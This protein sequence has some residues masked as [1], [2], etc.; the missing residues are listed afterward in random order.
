MAANG[1]PRERQ[2]YMTR[3]L[4][5][6]LYHL[7]TSWSSCGDHHVWQYQATM[8]LRHHSSKGE[9]LLLF[10]GGFDDLDQVRLSIRSIT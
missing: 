9:N 7:V 4:L 5:E 1:V 6:D 10:I 3:K 8:Q 2:I